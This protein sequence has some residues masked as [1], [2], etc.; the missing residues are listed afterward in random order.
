MGRDTTR[1][2]THGGTRVRQVTHAHCA[3]CC[4]ASIAGNCHSE[5][6]RG[7]TAARRPAFE[8]PA[9]TPNR[10]PLALASLVADLAPMRGTPSPSSWR[11][12]GW[13]SCPLAGPA[14]RASALTVG[15]R[16]VNNG[17]PSPQDDYAMLLI[18]QFKHSKAAPIF[19]GA[20]RRHSTH[21]GP[22]EAGAKRAHRGFDTQAAPGHPAVD[23]KWSATDEGGRWKPNILVQMAREFEGVMDPVWEDWV[24]RVGRRRLLLSV[25][26]RRQPFQ[27]GRNGSDPPLRRGRGRG[28]APA[29]VKSCLRSVWITN[30]RV[31]GQRRFGPPAG[32][33][34][35]PSALAGTDCLLRAA[36]TIRLLNPYLRR[37]SS[38][39]RHVTE[40]D[41]SLCNGSRMVLDNGDVEGRSSR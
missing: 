29:Q 34:A 7:R 12:D 5:L 20:R 41:R 8:R 3:G 10:A 22:D 30:P 16:R 23:G 24:Q 36:A 11:W 19:R 9:A 37:R 6:R 1:R 32:D 26:A 33:T 27:H 15:A 25:L 35:P 38:C 18:D 21:P 13:P 4:S 39:R 14:L 31:D 28:H 17:P 2:L 40:L